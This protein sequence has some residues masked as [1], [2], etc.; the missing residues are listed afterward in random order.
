MNA[1]MSPLMRGALADAIR[2]LAGR[3]GG[4]FSE[5]TVAR[6]VEDSFE[7]IGD[8]PTVGPNFKSMFV[9]RFAR[10]R[11]AAAAQADGIVAKPVPD[12]LFVCEH[13]AGRSR[14]PPR[15]RTSSPTGRS[16]C[17]RR[18]RARSRRSTPWLWT[19]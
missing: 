9:Q 2:R 19:R 12:L 4:V 13:N 14:M 15:W 11:L 18:G 5:E 17:V 7:R 6:C 8:R 3:F 1:E 10:E 16:L